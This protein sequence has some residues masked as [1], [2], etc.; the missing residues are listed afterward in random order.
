MLLRRLAGLL[1]DELASERE[2]RVVRGFGVV[3]K[4]LS[5]RLS[6]DHEGGGA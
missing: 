3:V 2:K 1:R 5:R 4:A 6:T